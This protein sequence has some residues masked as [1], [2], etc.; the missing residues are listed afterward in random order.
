MRSI[1]QTV[2]VGA[3]IA[4]TG[5]GAHAGA[6]VPAGPPQSAA[7]PERDGWNDSVTLALVTRATTR[8]QAQLADT[9]LR[10]YR[11]LARGF[12]T[13]LGQVGEGLS[14]PPRVIQATQVAT[15]VYWHAPNLSKQRVVGTRDT[16]VLPTD[17]DFYRDRYQIVQ[18]NFAD[19][20]RVG[21]GRDVADVPHP[22]SPRGS[23][24]YE[25]A[26]RDSLRI[27]SGDRTLSV[28]E[29]QVRPRDP[30]APRLVG[31]LFLD[32]D[33]AQV[34]RMAFTFTRAA[35]LDKRNEDV[36]IVLENALVQGRFWL[37]RRQ[38]VEVRRTGT[39]MDFPARGIIRG[40]WEIGSYAVNT[41][42]PLATFGGPELTFLPPEQRRRYAFGGGSV[43]DS[44]PADVRMVTDEDVRRV[45]TQARAL[46]QQQVLARTRSSAL[47]ARR[48]SDFARVNRVEGLALGAGWAARLGNGVAF[49]TQGRYG[50]DDNAVKGRATLA[51]RWA[52]GAAVRLSGYR[53]FRE[54]GD[55]PEVSLARNSLAAQE[56]GS[57]WTDPYLARGAELAVDA[58]RETGLRATFSAAWERQSALAVHAAP[59]AGR[60]EPTIPAARL[61]LL[62]VGMEVARPPSLGPL[63]VEWRLAGSL[64]TQLFA[65]GPACGDVGFPGRQ[66]AFPL[67][68]DDVTCDATLR[69][70][71]TLGVERAVGRHRLVS[72]TSAAAVRGPAPV[73]ELAYFGGPVTAPGYRF[74]ELV[75]L[76]GAT[77][78]LEWRTPVPFVPFS[79][80]RYGRAPASATL[81]PYANVVYLHRAATR[82]EG[83]ARGAG[84]YP[85]L[86]VGAYT[87]FDLVRFD[88]ARGLRDGRWLFSVDVTRDFW[89]VL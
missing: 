82:Y 5:G 84:W 67:A 42:L 26:V 21:E 86:G 27:R 54:A 35:Y 63:G 76:G 61:S 58:S 17:N 74:H 57:D 77:Q 66:E 80:G 73:Q 20:I 52:G 19:I 7:R 44:L 6:Q 45:Q 68:I 37:P 28:L 83:P 64:R 50:I 62:R 34:V 65:T 69:G 59:F 48:I 47:S 85:S 38:E 23:G 25:F 30:E 3:V 89:R 49:T 70:A 41:G 33:D 60:Y 29:V 8:R 72:R 88:V 51:R 13:F 10:D 16:T 4:A 79:L 36:S 11:A 12:L 18:N 22:L 31:A 43:L 78:R 15:E 1:W 56:F 24:Q 71:V 9:A 55:E 87:F 2:V 53:D 39:W 40:R 46:V 81:A 75:G 32:R 14:E